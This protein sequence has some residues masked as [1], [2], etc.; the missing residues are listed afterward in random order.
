MS[1]PHHAKNHSIHPSEAF[2]HS[3]K[4]SCRRS[5]QNKQR[6]APN[7]K[8]PSSSHSPSDSAIFSC[9]RQIPSSPVVVLEP[10]PILCPQSPDQHCIPSEH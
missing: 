6:Q 8:T 2:Q 7:A 10:D 9:T 1:I 5:R 4:I 3:A